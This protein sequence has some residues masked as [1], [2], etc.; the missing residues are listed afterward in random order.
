MKTRRLTGFISLVTIVAALFP[1]AAASAGPTDLG[2]DL[3]KYVDPLIGTAPPG[4]INP[5]PAVPYGMVDVGPDTEGPINY[6]GYYYINNTI[7]G[8]SHIH[9]SA[10]V[11]RGGEIPIMPVTGPV[12][13]GDNINDAT[14]GQGSPVPNYSSPF[15]HATE[16]AEA[17]YY[18]VLLEKYATTAELTATT[19]VGVHRYTFPAGVAASVVIDPS[20]DL[21]G[22]QN[23]ASVSADGQYV[24]GYVVSDDAGGVKVYF[25][26]TF[27]RAFTT[28]ITG[29]TAV[30]SFDSAGGRVIGK[31]GISY[32][33]IDG[34]KANIAAEVPGWDFD[35]VHSAARAAWNEALG[36]IEVTSSNPADLISFYTAL[37]H[38]QLFPN[39]VSDADGRYLG[40]EAEAGQTPQIHQSDRPHYSEFSLWDSYRGQNQ[41]LAVINPDAYL[42]MTLS[43]LDMY[44]QGGYL[45]RWTYANRDPGH[46]SGDPVIPF[47]GE[48]WCRGVLDGMSQDDAA[49][50]MQGMRALRDRRNPDYDALGYIPVGRPANSWFDALQ[51]GESQAGTTLEYGIADFSL[52]LMQHQAEGA[53]DQRALDGSTRYRNLMDLDAVHAGS[54]NSGWNRARHSDG[55]WLQEFIPENGYG[56]QEGTSWQYSWLAMQDLGGLIERM[57][58]DANV[59][60]RLDKFFN[61]PA[62]AAPVAWPKVQNQTTVFGIDYHGN[63]YAPGNEHDLEVP[64]VYN[65]AGAPWKTQAVTRG[66]LSIYT[67]TP[68]GLP[69]NDDL[70]ALSGWVVWSMLGIYPITPGAPLYTLASP[71]FETATLHM[72]D[73]DLSINAPGTTYASKYIQSVSL[74]GAPVTKTW[75]TESAF[76][77]GAHTLDFTLSAAPSMTWGTGDAAAPPSLSTNPLSDFGCSAALD[78]TE[79]EQ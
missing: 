32:V 18:K 25:A 24:T 77:D 74:D 44:R 3:A 48:G 29:N 54:G 47:I 1:V 35:A 53:A 78:L 31:V 70:G 34:A 55:S 21:K 38:A 39:I 57:G 52:A 27:D 75:L 42:D 69:G 79:D 9:M 5:G 15:N 43:L 19:H 51:G 58:G 71:V 72:A 45:P 64:Y 30:L 20:R 62:S 10:G 23:D 16:T 76:S 37:Y 46:M 22:Y 26:A 13:L 73:G 14:L 67:P 41:L 8:F 66:A 56:Y 49:E 28:Q 2:T 61:L 60:D 12:Q 65:Y 33:D 17:G 50:L 63:Q 11:A 6:G 36:T 7:T 68:D 59:Q 4:M 40:F